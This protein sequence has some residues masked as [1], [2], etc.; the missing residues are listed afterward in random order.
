[1]ISV[2]LIS[3]ENKEKQEFKV[4]HL[5]FTH[6]RSSHRGCKQN[7]VEYEFFDSMQNWSSSG[8]SFIRIAKAT[9]FW[10]N[11]P[12]KIYGITCSTLYLFYFGAPHFIITRIFW[13]KIFVAASNK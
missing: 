6:K 8:M 1:M 12:D 5:H 11:E 4:E 9:A 2:I 13:S 7:P 10:L 3:G